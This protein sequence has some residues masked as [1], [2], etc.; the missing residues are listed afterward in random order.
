MKDKHKDKDKYSDDMKTKEDY[1]KDQPK[2]DYAKDKPKDD[3]GAAGRSGGVGVD[4]NVDA[5]V[6]AGVLKK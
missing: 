3:H 5:N 2:D 4:A 1:A 6:D